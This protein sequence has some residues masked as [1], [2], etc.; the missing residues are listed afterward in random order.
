VSI[1]RSDH[2]LNNHFEPA[3]LRALQPDG[4]EYQSLLGSRYAVDAAELR[5]LQHNLPER[6]RA[7]GHHDVQ[8]LHGPHI[9]NVGRHSR[10]LLLAAENH[11]SAHSDEHSAVLPRTR[12]AQGQEL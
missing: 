4:V 1:H 10:N 11:R 7:I 12:P 3:L 2:S 5:S 9:L 6:D 8:T